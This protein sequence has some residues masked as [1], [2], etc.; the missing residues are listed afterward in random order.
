MAT[1]DFAGSFE[2]NNEGSRGWSVLKTYSDRVKANRRN[3]ASRAFLLHTG[4]LTGLKFDSHNNEEES[5]DS[6]DRALKLLLRR[7][8]D[9]MEYTGFDGVAVQKMEEEALR[10]GLLWSSLLRFEHSMDE[11]LQQRLAASQRILTG[12]D[13]FVWITAIEPASTLED[14]NNQIQ[15]LRQEIYRN[16]AA[17][18]IILLFAGSSNHDSHAE[19][20]PYRIT[21]EQWIQNFSVE[22]QGNVFH[23]LEP[24]SSEFPSDRMLVLMPGERAFFRT[25]NGMTV[26]RIPAGQLCQIEFDFRQQRKA[27]TQHWIGFQEALRHQR[28]IPADPGIQKILRH[29]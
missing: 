4:D 29:K 26:C 12:P 23:P 27:I 24:S 11:M 21:A 22:P 6:D 5:M 2:L 16:R 19:M 17:T 1:S 13:T 20:E 3:A 15:Q 9:L 28:F 7:G 8:V 25:I 10:D 14:M 18:L